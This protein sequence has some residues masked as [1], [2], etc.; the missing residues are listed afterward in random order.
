MKDIQHKELLIK[1]L[2]TLFLSWG[3]DAP[4]E[5]CWGAN[6]LVFHLIL[7]EFISFTIFS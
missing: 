6:E 3:S 7:S 4:A 5:V 2:E 1:S